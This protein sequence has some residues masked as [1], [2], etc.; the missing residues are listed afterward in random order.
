[1]MKNLHD[2]AEHNPPAQQE[3][4][5]STRQITTTSR[6]LRRPRPTSRQQLT[7]TSANSNTK[8][9]QPPAQQNP[10][11]GVNRPRLHESSDDAEGSL[12]SSKPGRSLGFSSRQPYR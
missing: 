6:H 2:R 9:V 11:N 7:P 5:D 1:M 8:V 3:P 10:P 4:L 12:P